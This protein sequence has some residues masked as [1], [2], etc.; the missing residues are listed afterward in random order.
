M[1]GVLP[2]TNFV[3]LGV[4]PF[5]PLI[6]WLHFNLYRLN[7][8]QIW[9]SLTRRCHARWRGLALILPIMAIGKA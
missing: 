9:S 7:R 5:N 4:L 8:A 6:K 3:I 1:L 2:L